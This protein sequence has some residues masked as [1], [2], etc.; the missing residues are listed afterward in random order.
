MDK[1]RSIAAPL[2]ACVSAGFLP[3]AYIAGYYFLGTAN[4]CEPAKETTRMFDLELVAALYRP[5]ATFEHLCVGHDV[6]IMGP[7]GKQP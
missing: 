4:Y 6:V 7:S 2:L 1:P 5:A 3:A